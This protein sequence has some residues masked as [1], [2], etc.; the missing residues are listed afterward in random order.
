MRRSWYTVNMTA[1]Q[2]ALFGILFLVLAGTLTGA[3]V[4]AQR[5][6]GD[7]KIVCTAEAKL[8][9]DGSYV[10]RSGS[11]CDFSPCPSSNTHFK[12]FSNLDLGI[13]YKYPER[14]PTEYVEVVDW[15]PRIKIL[16]GPLSCNTLVS[17]N[18]RAETLG[19]RT[20]NGRSYCAAKEVQGAAGSIY[21]QHAY[22]TSI[23]DKVVFLTFSLRTP[24][25]DN[26]EEP[27]RSTC[28][29]E[30]SAFSVDDLTDQIVSTLILKDPKTK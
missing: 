24:Q 17:N 21:T 27:K 7:E 22:T 20:L 26:Y 2:K 9:P 11:T 23:D 8:C 13:S 28:K 15:P 29:N 3:L 30:Q 14:L 18:G 10:S 19:N 25:C 1:I 6:T 4:V 16:N 12:T 5:N